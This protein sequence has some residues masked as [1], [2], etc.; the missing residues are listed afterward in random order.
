MLL[1]LTAIIYWIIKRR[2]WQRLL[3]DNNIPGPDCGFLFG[4]I[5]DVWSN[6]V[7]V[8]DKWFRQYGKVFSAFEAGPEVVIADPELVRR[9]QI[10]DFKMFTQRRR[11][12]PFGGI[13][14]DPQ[15]SVSLIDD[16]IS[17]IRWKEQRSLIATAFTSSKLKS[18]VPLVNE[19]IDDLL[20]NIDQHAGSGQDFDIYHY[21][22]LLTMDTIG[23]SAFGVHLNVQKNPDNEFMIALKKIFEDTLSVWY[24][25]PTFL[26]YAWPEFF[27][28]LFPIRYALRVI[29]KLIGK[30]THFTYQIE[31][32]KKIIEER[33]KDPSARKDDFLQRM[34]DASLTQEEMDRMN[35]NETLE[36]PAKSQTAS[37]KKI[38][39]TDQEVAAN[40]NLFFEAG[41]ETTSTFLGF[42]AHVLVSRQD[43]QDEIR[44]EVNEFYETE[45]SLG[46][47]TF[48]SLPYLESVMYETLRYFPPVTRFVTRNSTVDYKYKDMTIPADVHVEI[49]VAFM[50]HDPENW[51]DPVT[52]D[53]LRFYGENKSKTSS[54][55]YQAFGAG[56]RNCP[57]LRFAI[58]E[59][60]LTLA[61]LLH[62]YKLLPGTRTES[63]YDLKIDH[64]VITQTPKGVFVQ[65]ERVTR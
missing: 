38:K 12:F 61:R 43:V 18:Y 14:A 31:S 32:C 47:N 6:D 42:V 57:G 59:A 53:P 19:G 15:H 11:F 39:L 49:S 29:L 3:K 5:F 48:S 13:D 41:F 22:Q 44:K 52:F 30:P 50:H 25:W 27:P 34:I 7:A 46:H 37:Y 24:T 54:I 16:D 26:N 17:P 58:M 20:D 4:N 23:R 10:K 63:F 62:N 21:F 36:D 35:G 1:I 8:F 9:I 45:G 65:V 51:D 40:A 56:P 60:K 28:V 2:R 64:K 55:A 33:K